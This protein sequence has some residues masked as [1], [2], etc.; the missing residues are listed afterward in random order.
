MQMAEYP[1][2]VPTSMARCT[3]RARTRIVMK[4]PCSGAICIPAMRP[5]AR[6]SWA[7]SVRT[8]SSGRLCSS[9]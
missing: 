9:R 4:T 7:S 1:V 2:K 3:P 8:S 5:K 6:V